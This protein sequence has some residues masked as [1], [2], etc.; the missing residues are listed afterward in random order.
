MP[1]S[2]AS[3]GGCLLPEEVHLQLPPPAPTHPLLHPVTRG[4]LC[5]AQV[6]RRQH[7]LH[8]LTRPTPQ[9]HEGGVATSCQLQL[10]EAQGALGQ[11]HVTHEPASS[12]SVKL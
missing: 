8:K 12:K 7:L 10:P 4:T 1:G 2:L 6:Q 9:Q 5:R 11:G 3:K